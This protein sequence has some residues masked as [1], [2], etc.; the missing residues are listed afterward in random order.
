MKKINSRVSIYG[1]T[2]ELRIKLQPHT[3]VTWDSLKKSLEKSKGQPFSDSAF[4]NHIINEIV[5]PPANSFMTLSNSLSIPVA[6]TK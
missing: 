2:H 4:F 6:I 1:A 3:K 5:I